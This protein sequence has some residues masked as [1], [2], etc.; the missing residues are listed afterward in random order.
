MICRQ[1][2]DRDIAAQAAVVRA[3]DLAHPALAEPAG[4]LVGTELRASRQ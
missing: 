3:V 2:L 4:D 1:D